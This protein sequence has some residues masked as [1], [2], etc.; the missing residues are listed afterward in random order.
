M[1]KKGMLV[2]TTLTVLLFAC[3]NRKIVQT[4]EEVLI[5][6]EIIEASFQEMIPGQQGVKPYMVLN[7]IFAN[8]EVAE[9][10]ASYLNDQIPLMKRGETYQGNCPQ[11]YSF[12]K[13]EQ[14]K[15]TISYSWRGQSYST[16]FTD[17]E[18]KEALYLP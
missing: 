13:E 3:S 8:D 6:M 18:I 2:F 12:K 5:N 16:E 10:R 11:V 17:V 15:L 1:W 7:V 14:I 9:C 4:T